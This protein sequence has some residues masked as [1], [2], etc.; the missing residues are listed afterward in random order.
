MSLAIAALH[1]E[2]ETVLHDPQCVDIS[3]PDFFT[4]L[5]TVM[6]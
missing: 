5:E 3:Y 6:V 4:T 2:R 1:A